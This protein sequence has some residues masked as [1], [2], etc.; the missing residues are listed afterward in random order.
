MTST[1]STT[2][3]LKE[4]DGLIQQQQFAAARPTAE[5]LVQQAPTTPGVMERAILVLRQL[6][7]WAALT[8]LLLEARN[9]YQLW[10]HGSD[11]MMGQGMVELNQ[12]DQAIPYLELA[13]NNE[14]DGGWP[15]HFL[16]KAFR[17][18]G[19]LEEA[20]EQQRKAAEQ[21]PDFAWAP[22]EAAQVLMELQQQQL[23][24]LELQEARRRHGEPHAV[25]EEQWQK[26]Q[27]LVMLNRVEQL[28][29]RG[30]LS[31][32]FSVLRQALIHSPDDEV[33]NSKLPDLLTF[34]GNDS[35]QTDPEEVNT[36]ALEQEL[37]SIEALL[38]QLEAESK[39]F[40]EPT[41]SLKSVVNGEMSY[42]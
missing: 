29:A 25:I 31:E 2:L 16:G 30:E 11:L 39:G 34:I 23:A 36:S 10:P 15:H 21:L 4:L 32:A 37:N 26:L 1:T 3:A 38:D 33:L 8:Q 20:L 12:W 19:R 28:Q 40:V 42:F 22:F 17:H 27:P 41:Q 24:V 18:T 35:S 14:S 9:R 7:D 13:V 5:A 6:G